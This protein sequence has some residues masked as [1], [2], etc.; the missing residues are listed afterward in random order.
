MEACHFWQISVSGYGCRRICDSGLEEAE[1]SGGAKPT[2]RV[3]SGARGLPSPD[4]HGGKT[5]GPGRWGYAG[6]AARADGAKE[7]SATQ[8]AVRE[9]DGA[10]YSAGMEGDV[11]L[12]F[13]GARLPAGCNNA[14]LEISKASSDKL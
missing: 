6:K 1:R 2:L 13:T 11:R 8:A 7:N 9:A 5:A 3:G 12:R 14:I 4:R 10:A